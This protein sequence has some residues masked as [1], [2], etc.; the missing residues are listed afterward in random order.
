MA[1]WRFYG[2]ET[3][4]AELELS[5]RLHED[6]RRFDA[7]RINGRRGIGKTEF[8]QE[9][10]RRG[11]GDPP[12][13]HVELPSPE[14]GDAAS[15]CDRLIVAAKSKGLKDVFGS[16]PERQSFH[17]DMMWFG[18]HLK[19]LIAAGAIVVLDEFH[20]ARPLGLVSDVKLVIDGFTSVAAPRVSGELVMMGSHQQQLYRMFRSDQPLYGRAT[21]KVH[22]PPWPVGTVLEMA[23]DQG[24]LQRPARF[25]TLW[26]AY[27]GV[28][29]HWHR[30]ANSNRT[31]K[32]RDF[33]LWPDDSAWRRAFLDDERRLLADP[34]ERFD[35]AAY[36][37]L[38]PQTRE[39]LLWLARNCP[40]GATTDELQVGLS[41]SGDQEILDSLWVLR[42]H[43]E[44]VEPKGQ[45]QVKGTARWR[46]I[47][48][49]TLFQITVYPELFET[50]R[51]QRVECDI[52]AEGYNRRAAAAENE[53]LALERF[54]AACFG[55][56]TDIS[57]SG[58]G[59]WRQRRKPP[60]NDSNGLKLP[61]LADIDVMALRGEWR[62]PDPVL[63]L[64]GCKR[65]AGRHH[66][67]RLDAQFG[68]FLEDLG[69]EATATR[70]RALPQ[71]RFLISPE[72]TDEQRMK[73]R[74]AGFGCL[75]IRDLSQ[76]LGVD[77]GPEPESQT[78][79]RPEPRAP[80]PR[81]VPES[82]NGPSLDM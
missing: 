4:L 44:L 28:P 81:K 10:A 26:S 37:E 13:L 20:H 68:A 70:R 61:P 17:N 59:L 77:P 62:D 78:E 16:L 7:V 69:T 76:M 41:K 14:L 66:P 50:R 24:F 57:W 49:N 67:A 40:R 42:R 53:G 52:D 31:A 51:D 73:A 48:N 19:E 21:S 18:L 5:L 3:E 30:F 36:V 38:A 55:E 46:I 9:A 74:R 58:D 11:T 80:V 33:T 23:A 75:G 54:A 64:A 56:M 82:E 27:G 72:F 71:E 32:L 63:I 65:N 1:G 47:D 22:L 15:A 39:V 29:K 79:P 25:L 60:F 35:N 12:V 43:L 8:M 45:F 6:T 2:R 34:E